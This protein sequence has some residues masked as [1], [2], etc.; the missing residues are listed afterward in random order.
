MTFNCNICART[1]ISDT[2]I[3]ESCKK[4][5]KQQDNL[6]KEI[7]QIKNK[8]LKRAYKRDKR[9]FDENSLYF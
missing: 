1:L 9:E 6:I 7:E 2:I 5:K 8:A 3:C 4:I